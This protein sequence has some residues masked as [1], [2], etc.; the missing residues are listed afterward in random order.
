MSD[1]P[2]PAQLDI[3]TAPGPIWT[4]LSVVWI[5]PLLAMLISLGVAW[6]SFNDRGVL[7]H[8]TFDNAAGLVPGQSV[9]KYRQVVVGKV[10]KVGFTE[11]LNRVLVSVRV[12]K[13]VAPHI[14]AK[15]KFWIVRPE[16]GFSGVSGLDT[17]LSGVFI[18]GLWDKAYSGPP[19]VRFAGLDKP[20]LAQDAGSGTWVT[21]ANKDGG[22]LIEGAP[23]LYR[24][25]KVG[26]LRNLRISDD[27]ENVLINAFVE[28]P[29]DKQLT[30]STV[31]WDTSGFSV[32]LGPSGVKLNVRSLSS[33]IQGGVEFNT[34]VSGGAPIAPE[35]QFHLF[36]DETA[37]RDSI[38]ADSQAARVSFSIL[39]DG[40]VRGLK[41]GDAVNFRGIKVGE[42]TNLTVQADP[43]PNG[44]RIV[45]Q[46]VD[47]V[48]N[49]ERMGL[50]RNSNAAD[51][52]SFLQAEVAEHLRARVA[53]TGLLGGSLVIDLIP[54]P[55]AP[56]ARIDPTATPFPVIP[57][58][59]PDIAD[60]SATAEGVL[61]R[62]NALPIE[63]VMNS[64]IA[65]LDQLTKFVGQDDT[66]KAPK[67][68]V[69]LIGDIRGIVGS[70]DAQ[71]APAALH[72]TLTNADKF[73]S[74]L[75]SAG[76]V[77]SI[78]TAM[79][80]ASSAANSVY[81]ATDGVPA[82]V[83]TY[84]TLGQTVNKMPLED[85]ASNARDLIA[86][87][88]TLTASP[89]VA[90]LPKSL[91]DAL[92][93]LNAILI[94]LRQ[95]GATQKLNDTLASAQSAAADVSKASSQLPELIT[96]LDGV[97]NGANSVLAAY[98]SNSPFS[99]ETLAALRKLRNAAAS[100]DSLARTLER[101]PQALI[102][103]R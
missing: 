66:Q 37:A 83:T 13:D 84:T 20:P 59:P 89:D 55:D 71:A 43:G 91:T 72:D 33:L 103:G 87:L 90:A 69:G 29:Y 82:L 75:N 81:A 54:V 41:L 27:G 24:G 2:T 7:I 62:V 23:V 36:S 48:L 51:V 50:A 34:I 100:I 56:P 95:G 53:S 92:D 3:R 30:T 64:A 8:I 21:L 70:A 4:R 5:V 99:D 26:E 79:T 49:P 65:L 78:V 67:E 101:N 57:S 10:E 32:S 98:G 85:V 68:L 74:D 18:E 52:M 22:T 15:A 77:Q 45:R 86:S 14:D 17:V 9:L 38:F 46:R 94:D 80:D 96:K 39:L 44:G 97:V 25:I 93:S 19:P 12:D 63:Q 102:L 73:I 31:F 1:D 61:A 42:V 40:S 11:D 16:I 47:F 88:N 76:T 6:K 60:V 35:H 58:V 28:A